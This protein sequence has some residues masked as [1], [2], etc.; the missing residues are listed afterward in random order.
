MTSTI[1][2]YCALSI[3]TT[4][5]IEPAHS[6]ATADTRRADQEA[7]P[8]I[9]LVANRRC[10]NDWNF[11][12]I[13]QQLGTQRQFPIGPDDKEDSEISRIHASTGSKKAK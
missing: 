6:V 1:A 2:T 4:L 10:L 7:P 13:G 8:R 5:E 12:R 3:P 11:C 9:A